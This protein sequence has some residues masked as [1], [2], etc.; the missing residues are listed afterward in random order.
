MTSIARFRP[1][2]ILARGLGISDGDAATVVVALAAAAVLTI[3]GLPPVL[4]HDDTP[5]QTGSMAPSAPAAAAAPITAPA[6]APA[7]ETN[8]GAQ[9][10]T[11]SEPGVHDGRTMP[12]TAG[13]GKAEA[14]AP[15]SGPGAAGVPLPPRRGTALFTTVGAP[16]APH[17]LVVAG[18]GTLYVATNNG[19][20]QGIPGPSRILSFRAD[21]TTGPSFMITGQ[22]DDHEFGLT[23]LTID[24]AGGLIAL[25]AATGR[26]LQIDPSTGAQAEYAVLVDLPAC[27]LIVAAPQ[28]CELGLQDDRPVPIDAVFDSGGRLLVADGGQGIVWEIPPDGGEPLMW[29]RHLDFALP[30]ALSAITIDSQ[31]DVLLV[32]PQT[33]SPASPAGGA[34]YRVAVGGDGT[35]SGSDVLATFGPGVGPAG[36]VTLDD[37]SLVVTLRD[38]NAIVRLSTDGAEQERVN[39]TTGYGLDGPTGLHLWGA[40]LLATNQA[41]AAPDRASVVVVGLA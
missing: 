36:I 7:S 12:S 33:L 17:G 20:A 40:T 35:A 6:P 31:G 21:G 29:F 27:G 38:A 37:G 1:T 4:R 11:S 22:P 19:T 24:A 39:A 2:L 13:G 25:D 8:L 14:A 41:P 30:D 10:S 18:D 23:G 26:V 34:I 5:Q 9:R 3:A 28:G 32:S 15:D 16:G